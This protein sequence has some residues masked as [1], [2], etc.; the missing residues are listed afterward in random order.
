MEFVEAKSILAPRSEGD[1]WFG[2]NYNMNIYRGCCHGCIYCD[3]RSDCYH[4]EDFDRVRSK[5]DVL[6][7]LRRELST[8]RKTGIVGNGAMSD[9]YNP[10]EKEYRLTRGSLELILSAGFGAEVMT[11]SALVE[12]DLDI[13]HEISKYAP[14]VV[15]MSI[16]STDDDLAKKIEPN[17]S[18]FSERFAALEKAASMGITT[19]I[20]LVPILPLITDNAENIL[21]VVRRAAECRVKYIYAGGLTLR[22]N[23]RDYYFDRLDELFPGY[24]DEYIRRYGESYSCPPPQAR[25]LY[26]IF[27]KECGRLGLVCRMRDIIRI[28]NERYSQEQLSIF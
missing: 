9:P 8:K 3:S 24:K 26:T 1:Q 15:N 28:I 14:A 22:I 2:I 6:G 23:Q 12:R 5:K 7:I 13:F 18:V 10:F 17:A 27:Q 16:I 19:G 20:L 11:K 4:V 25:E 21:S